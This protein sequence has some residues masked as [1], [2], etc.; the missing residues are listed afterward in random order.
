M[1]GHASAD[2]HPLYPTDSTA[3]CATADASAQRTAQQTAQYS[4][5]LSTAQCVT[6]DGSAQC[7]VS[8]QCPPPD[9][10]CAHQRAWL[11]VAFA[12]TGY[13]AH[14]RA[15]SQAGP[16]R[17]VYTVQ[18]TVQHSTMCP[19]IH[20]STA[21]ALVLCSVSQWMAHHSRQHSTAK[22]VTADGSAQRNVSQWTAQHSTTDS[23]AQLSMSHWMAQHC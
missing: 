14:P 15:Q 3:E 22:C 18:Q 19:N 9:R 4:K 1:K 12:Q 23:I 11:R 17:L 7:S 21:D 5:Q 10:A 16:L 13:A 6:A 20:H 2:L 8:Q